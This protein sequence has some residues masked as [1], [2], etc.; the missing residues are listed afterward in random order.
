MA[1][2]KPLSIPVTYGVLLSVLMVSAPHVDHVPLWVSA[3]CALALLW[4]GYLARA[5]LPLPA[6]WLPSLIT[7]GG[8]VG[9]LVEFRTLFGQEVSVTLLVM[10]TSLKLLEMRT[11]RDATLV[12]YLAC[13]DIIT[14]FLYSQNIP[15][16]LFMFATLLTIVAT[17]LH[18]QSAALK[19]RL[20]LRI[21]SLLLL[22]SIPLMLV[23]F[24]LFPRVQ[25]PLWS[26]PQDDLSRTGLTD[27]MSPGSISKLSLSDEIAFRVTFKGMAPMREQ[28][29][30]RGPVLAEY[31]GRN[32]TMARA[33]PGKPPQLDNLSGQVDYT[34]MLE[35]H[36][37]TWLFALEMPTRVS[38]SSAMTFDFQLRQKDP[39]STRMQYDVQSQL[40]YRANA[41][42]NQFQLRQALQLPPTVNPRAR[43]LA[44]DWRATYKNPEFISLAA[45]RYFGQ[46]GFSYTLEPPP[47]GA[48]AVDDFVFET[49][50]GFCEHFASSYV[51]LMRA[52]GVPARVV[53]GYQGGEFNELGGYYIVR[54]S[55]AH[56]WA[57]VWLEGRGWVRVDPTAA[58]SPARVQNGLAAAVP[59]NAA[60]PLM[61]RTSS[62]WLLKLRFNMDLIAY[63]W[64]QWVLGY[65]ALRQYSLLR[66]LGMTDI[67]WQ[68]M[69]LYLLGFLGLLVGTFALLMLRRL[70]AHRASEAQRLYQKFC[71]KLD[72]AGV[73]RA[74]HEG[75]QDF[76][77]R[78]ARACPQQAGAISAITVLY[79]A[80]RYAGADAAS[81][82]PA[83]R[84]AVAAFRL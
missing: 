58:V 36:Y 14:N 5:G 20:R 16:A 38:T 67:T 8:I 84:R 17:W 22:Q 79:V 53:T 3:L 19:W 39:V 65:D 68:K 46:Q 48:N 62:S 55:D 57:E 23:L 18:L 34:V 26:M 72:K 15:T 40:N 21:A 70:Y 11:A 41:E 45:L 75:P 9:L 30:W 81:E 32:W 1:E 31:D 35:P 63:Q 43:Q 54:Q 61:A 28:M 2:P 69:G 64:N 44:E 78:A 50:K 52:A 59:N 10:L 13:F 56:A 25:G 37:K 7:V 6:R 51:F 82:L 42:E 49:R 77:A 4:R 60:L 73:T 29:Y 12:I 33:L 74:D 71:R 80:L 66:K 27:T 24:V 83:L 76:A 47:L